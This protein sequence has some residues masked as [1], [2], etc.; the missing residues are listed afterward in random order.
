[1][2][3]ADTSVWIGHFRFG[4][5]VLAG[6]LGRGQVLGHDFVTGEL[7]CG[8]IPQRVETLRLLSSLPQA[9]VAFHEEVLRV[10]DLHDVAG[11][12][13]GYVDAHLLAATLLT[14]DARLWTRDRRL[15]LVAGRLDRGWGPP[16]AG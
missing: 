1:M 10:I 16:E 11:A 6:L 2:I 5:P 15:A 4:D 12:G 13:I 8:M 7:A 14:P 3:L 9:H